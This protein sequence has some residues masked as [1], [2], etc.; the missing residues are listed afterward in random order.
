MDTDRRKR[1]RIP[2]ETDL[3]LVVF[4]SSSKGILNGKDLIKLRKAMIVDVSLAGLRIKTSDLQES[5][6]FHLQ[7]GSIGL[8]LKFKLDG[9]DG[10]INAMAEV[11]WIEALPAWEKESHIVGLK[12]KDIKQEDADKI[13]AF[14]NRKASGK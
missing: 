1:L 3:T 4:D 14:I 9:V 11:A 7:S 6:A 12:F 8:A 10:P 13:A 5:W 2:I